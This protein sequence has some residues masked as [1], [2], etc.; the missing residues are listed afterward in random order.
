MKRN[1]YGINIDEGIALTSED[2]FQILYIESDSKCESDLIEWIKNGNN[3]V[4][5]GGQ[6]GSGKTSAIQYAFRETK[7]NP[8]ITFHFDKNN[9]NLSELDC[10]VIVFA[11][12]AR[13]AVDKNINTITNVFPE[14]KD[15][16]GNTPEL[17]NETI[18]QV[19]LEN[20][21]TTAL[22][23]RRALV[24]VLEPIKEHLTVLLKTI[25]TALQEKY[26]HPILFFAAGVDKFELSKSPYISLQTILAALT[27]Y[28]IL[29]EVNIVHLFS[30]DPWTKG[31]KKIVL[32]ASSNDWITAMITKRLGAYAESYK[33]EIKVLV[34]CSG[35]IPR[36]ALRLLDS[37]LAEQKETKNKRS[38]MIN[39]IQNV[40]RD[41]FAFSRRPDK[42]LLKTVAKQNYLETT[43]ISV[44]GDATTAERA[45]FGN[46]II[47][48]HHKTESLWHATVNPIIKSSIFET[49]TTEEPLVTLLNTY[50]IQQGISTSGLDIKTGDVNLQQILLSEI[51]KPINLN[52]TEILNLIAAA[53]LSKDRADRIIVAYEDKSNFDAVRAY[54][55]AKSNTY[56]Y[57][58]WNH[59]EI[60]GGSNQ[61]PLTEMLK[62]FSEKPVDIYSFDFVGDY[63]DAE[64]EELNIRR[65][66]F[67]NKQIIW[68]IPKSKLNKYLE[69]W[70]QLRQL[71]QLFILEEDIAKTLKIE[72]IQDD[73]NFMIELVESQNTAPGKYVENLKVVLEYLKGVKNG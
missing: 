44:F 21:S 10:W 30:N 55:E 14:L 17:W 16:L 28:K 67:I 19:L 2:D 51:E 27:S 45:V 59:Y 47:L 57:Q 39:A 68:W 46:W 22:A 23:K 49:T 66:F 43:F 38:G 31:L 34:E 12:I 60:K 11:E 15:I 26:G 36:Q 4:L 53:L 56:E 58:I 3:A 41:F 63:T 6:I 61:N 40:N 24:S 37:F 29:F 70:T 1:K 7:S 62:I 13:F 48:K 69:R 8:D 73:L 72:D 5:F 25:I 18:P 64:L 42:A 71:F 35:G 54:L 65:D 33:E 52:I 9:L 32:T 20:F 50:G